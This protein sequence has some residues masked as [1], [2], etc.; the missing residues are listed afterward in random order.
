[1][2]SLLRRRPGT[3]TLDYRCDDDGMDVRDEAFRELV[4]LAESGS[5][6][7]LAVGSKRTADASSN[8]QRVWESASS[9]VRVVE[10]VAVGVG[11]SDEET[12]SRLMRVLDSVP[13]TPS[14]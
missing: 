8:S 4:T 3:V 9:A 1:M 12:Q 6:E 11:E 7:V 13:V 14:W 2:G 10:Q 5:G